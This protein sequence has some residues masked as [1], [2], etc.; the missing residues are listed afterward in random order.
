V[1]RGGE[2]G[3]VEPD[4]GDDGLGSASTDARDGV[5]AIEC[6]VKRV[7]PVLHLGVELFDELIQGVQM[8]Q[9]LGEQEALV[10]SELADER[11]L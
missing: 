8:R 9:L 3:H 2:P 7:Q 5:E 10:C 1:G 4:L 6:V 11:A